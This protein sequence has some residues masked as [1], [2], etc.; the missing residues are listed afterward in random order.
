LFAPLLC[1]ED[2]IVVRQQRGHGRVGEAD[3][4]AL[5]PLGYVSAARPVHKAHLIAGMAI[6]NPKNPPKKPTKMIFWGGLL[7]F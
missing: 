2:D 3:C 1:I 7:N 4:A 6:K 5:S